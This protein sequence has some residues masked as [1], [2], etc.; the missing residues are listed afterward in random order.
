MKRQI[1]I[2][3]AIEAAKTPP[4][5]L[6]EFKAKFNHCLKHTKGS[7]SCDWSPVYL[8]R[9]PARFK[10]RFARLIKLA[11]AFAVKLGQK[12]WEGRASLIMMALKAGFPRF[13][14]ASKALTA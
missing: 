14:V 4:L 6:K 12:P 8:T 10:P 13:K 9:D 1:N 11:E 3:A 7:R 2:G 5:S